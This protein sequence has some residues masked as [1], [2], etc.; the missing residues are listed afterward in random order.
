MLLLGEATGEEMS[1]KVAV[2]KE[3]RQSPGRCRNGKNGLGAAGL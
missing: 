1:E 3:G 2:P